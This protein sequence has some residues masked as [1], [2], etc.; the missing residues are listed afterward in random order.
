MDRA[1][2]PDDP[3]P[4]KPESPMFKDAKQHESKDGSEVGVKQV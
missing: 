1:V 2:L 4:V 3:H